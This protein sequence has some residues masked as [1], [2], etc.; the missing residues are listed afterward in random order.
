[1]KTI[2]IFILSSLIIGTSGC[3]IN[4]PGNGEKIG[5]I[6]KL[7]KQG[8][9]AETWEAELIRG[10]MSGGSGSFGMQPF[11]FTIEDNKTAEKVQEY[12]Q[13]QTEV[14]IKYKIEGIYSAFRSDSSGHFLISIEP[15]KKNLTNKP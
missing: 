5:Q 2:I 14:I 9:I 13:N 10:G 1:M 7:N 11:H 6:V 8:I 15:A 4:R 3:G 12:L